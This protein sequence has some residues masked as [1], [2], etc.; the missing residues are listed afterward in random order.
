VDVRAAVAEPTG[1]GVYT[2]ALL[3]ALAARG[4]LDLLALAHREPRAAGDLR[5]AGIRVERQ[6]AP[7]GLFWQQLLLPRRLAAGDIDLFWSPLLT[8]PRKLPVPAVL[9][10]HDLAV[11][12]VPETL[13]LKVR[14]SVLPFLERSIEQAAR[15]VV[16]SRR[17]AGE[18]ESAFPP[19]RG[20]VRVISHGVAD[21]FRPGSSEEVA[22]TRSRYAAP[23]GYFLAAGTLEP[24]KNLDLLLDAWERLAEEA[25]TAPLPLLLVGAPGWKNRSLRRRLER[26]APRG[27]RHLGRL[28]RAELAELFRGAT[29]LV[30]P[31]VYEG[32]GL[33]VAEA[34]ASGVPAV[35][36]RDTTPAEVA[37]DAGVLVDGEDP[38]ELAEALL[39]LTEGGE[40]RDHLV[41][42][43]LA[44]APRFDWQ[45]SAAELSGVFAE[46]LARSEP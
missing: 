19:A 2:L 7:L 27:V 4:E 46:A 24:R 18:V 9:T 45:R 35:V 38:T 26:L 1:I 31:S 15:I 12:R 22:E 17:V 44:R 30:Y 16:G 10:L 36:V 29:A 6:R 11:L 32:F 39:R 37:G 23:E 8:L 43:A 25:P 28:E 21:D 34:L 5:A 14:W 42:R 41:A 33:P 3:H 40:L 20:K 13:P